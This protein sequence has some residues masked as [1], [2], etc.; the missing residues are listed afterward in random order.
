MNQSRSIIIDYFPL[1]AIMISFIA[2]YFPSVFISLKPYIVILLAIIMFGMGV[3]LRIDDFK[4][5]LKKPASIFLGTF[6]QFILMP[7]IAFLLCVLFQLPKELMIG[8]ILVGC[9]PGGTA[10]NLICYLARGNVALSISLTTV[11]TFLS[12]LLTPLLTLI[13][14]GEIVS[15]PVHNMI[16]TILQIIIIPVILGLLINTYL[17]KKINNFIAVFPMLSVLSII[18]VIGIVIALNHNNIHK[19]TYLLVITV[20]LHNTTGFLL[21]YYISKLFKIDESQA[22]TISIEVG[23]QNSGLS[24]VLALKYFGAVASLPGTIFSIWHNIG[25]SILANIWGNSSNHKKT[26]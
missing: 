19:V 1:W 5:V 25:G 3:T 7:L 4:N 12:F 14:I 18:I 9:C 24:V 2:Y 6:L 26:T 16:L 21:G 22:R 13:Y 17:Y 20:I 10:S 11:S 15:V 23:M 8:L